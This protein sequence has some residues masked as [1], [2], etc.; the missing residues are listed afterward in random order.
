MNPPE[1]LPIKWRDLW[2][3]ASEGFIRGEPASVWDGTAVCSVLEELA[4]ACGRVAEL[5]A[6][7]AAHDLCHD[8]HGKVGPR[9]FADGC[10]AEQRK[11]YGCAPDADRVA[12]LSAENA[13]LRA[14]LAAAIRSPMGDVPDLAFEFYKPGGP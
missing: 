6:I 9:E 1:H 14:A 4:V 7:I 10:A 12:E 13:R 8:L 3:E 11:F 2:S 5:E